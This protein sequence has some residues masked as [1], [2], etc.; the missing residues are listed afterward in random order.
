MQFSWDENGSIV[1]DHA[2]KD[3][4]SGDRKYK[5]V[6]DVGTH[7]TRKLALHIIPT[8]VDRSDVVKV[9]DVIWHA[10]LFLEGKN[11]Q[12]CYVSHQ[13]VMFR[14]KGR[15]FGELLVI[16]SGRWPGR[17]SRSGLIP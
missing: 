10:L 1:L 8:R 4:Q 14:G 6:V 9:F 13:H 5:G 12:Q 7:L 2:R 3:D 17:S 15:R 16:L 11:R